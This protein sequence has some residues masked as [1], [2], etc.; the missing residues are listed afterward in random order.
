MKNNIFVILFIIGVVILVSCQTY[1]IPVESFEHQFATID[2]TSLKEVRIKGARHS[3]Y[4]ANPIKKIECVDKQ[5]NAYQ[6]D[7]GPSIEI[8][9]TY[10]E[11][12]KKAIFYFDRV[13]KQD[14][15]IIGGQSRIIPSL[16]KT[17]PF[18]TVSKIE[19]QDGEKNFR[20]VE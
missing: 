16:L 13:I 1:F 19:V 20:Y 6:L 3:T 2:S 7:N 12:N 10:G 15:L 11:K 4:L 8:R 9:F 17:I 5:G 14:S 18:S